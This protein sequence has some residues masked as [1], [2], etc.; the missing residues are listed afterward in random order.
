MDILGDTLPKIAYEKAGII[1]NNI[2]VIIVGISRRKP[3]QY[4]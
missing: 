1:K 4:F 3:I 2:P